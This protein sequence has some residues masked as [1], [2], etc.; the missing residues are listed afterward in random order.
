VRNVP[1]N[2]LLP[3][4]VTELED[5]ESREL[6]LAVAEARGEAYVPLNGAPVDSRA[7]LLEVHTVGTEPLLLLAMPVGAPTENGFLLRLARYDPTENVTQ[8]FAA[9]TGR[10]KQTTGD[11]LKLR[12]RTTTG[13][14][15]LTA[16]HAAA[17]SSDPPT[18]TSHVGRLIGGKLRIEQLVG[19]GGM[20]VVYRATHLGLRMPVAVKVLKTNLQQDLEFC[21]RF[22]EEALAASRLDHPN[23]TRVLDFGQEPDGL[24]YI[25][26]EFLDGTDLG[27]LID[28]DGRLPLPRIVDIMS[29]VCAGL[30]HMHSRGMVHSD[31]KPDNLI[32]VAGHDED[33]QPIEAAKLCDFGIAVTRGVAAT[34]VLGTPAYMSPEQCV[35]DDLD[36][37][38]DIYACGVMLY[39]M[40]TG[41]PPFET[42]DKEAMTAFHL[43]MDPRA[44]SRIHP[45][46]PRFESLILKALRKDRT[47]RYQ[48]A[49]EL[50]LALRALVAPPAEVQSPV[51]ST[52][53]PA[54]GR[55]KSAPPAPMPATRAE[56]PDWVEGNVGGVGAVEP[57][58]LQA[59]RLVKDHVRWLA[60]L[61]A[62]TDPEDFA[63][64]CSELEAA[65]PYIAKSARL[66]VM[67]RIRSTLAVIVE[68]G[69][70]TQG[71]RPSGAHRVLKAILDPRIL[72]P[73]AHD[74]LYG[75]PPSRQASGLLL[76]A[77]VGGA[78]VLYGA[79]TKSAA[80]DGEVRTR[81][82][83][84]MREI[85]TQAFPVLRAALEKLHGREED[86][87]ALLVDVLEAIPPIV[88]DATGEIVSRFLTCKAPEIRRVVTSALVRCWGERAQ[89]L[90][91]GLLKDEDESVRIAAI[92]GIRKI[93]RVDET[94]VRR[95]GAMLQPSHRMSTALKKEA[96]IA[97]RSA[98]LA[99]RPTAIAIL[100]RLVAAA[101]ASG[102][103]EEALLVEEARSLIS[104]GARDG[105]TVVSERASRQ[106][107]PL[108]GRLLELLG[109]G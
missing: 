15:H 100:T 64:R 77:G 31:L 25:A 16:G 69:P 8:R 12:P 93:G 21:R 94:V 26:M 65:L 38:S 56:R 79:R 73:A 50:R 83:A 58:Q 20:G 11:P 2:E 96:A 24:V 104:L 17:L 62:T 67:W 109:R 42:A 49:R 44:P 1:P 33:G 37:R 84:M 63:A 55:S 29:Q 7:H 35:G 53:S 107:E 41:R 98:A 13:L 105:A 70:A 66:D 48:S 74:L 89:A 106:K 72:A 54:T 97:Y 91:V 80:D 5:A 9:R 75:H 71:S 22:Q 6:L 34:E 52:A 92:A 28:R 23:L 19:S 81:F 46:D 61:A 36:A 30:M 10:E 59:D 99:G 47:V 18:E 40:A 14:H 68:E 27:T 102:P 3:I 60:D 32:L 76:A 101:P 85:G 88:D 108:R 45:I 39:E 90:L 4:L 51:P 78:Y 87:P 103:S 43:N 82:T 95:L 86:A 57:A